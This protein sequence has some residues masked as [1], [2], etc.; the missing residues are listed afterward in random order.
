MSNCKSVLTSNWKA[1][2]CHFSWSSFQ[3]LSYC[4]KFN[5]SWLNWGFNTLSNANVSL[6]I[7]RNFHTE[8][9]PCQLVIRHALENQNK[10]SRRMHLLAFVMGVEWENFLFSL[11]TGGVLK[12]GV[13]RNFAKFTGKHLCQNLFFNKV[14]GQRPATLLE[15]R[16]WQRCFPVNFAKYLRTHFF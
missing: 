9:F 15:K 6:G 16:F 12:K 13:L 7:L 14:A 5:F 11:A 3:R 8:K 2:M 4:Q 1:G 10:L